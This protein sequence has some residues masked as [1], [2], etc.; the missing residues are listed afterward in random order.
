MPGDLDDVWMPRVADEGWIAIGRDAK[1][2]TRPGERELFRRHGLRVFRIKGQKYMSTWD[3]LVRLVRLWDEIERIVRDRPTG[4]WFM[5]IHE[6]KIVEQ[7][8]FGGDA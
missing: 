4:P 8:L 3:E 6:T 5:A 2:R 7:A 1:L